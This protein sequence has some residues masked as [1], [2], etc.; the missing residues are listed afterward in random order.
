MKKAA[1]FI[2][3]LAVLLCGCKEQEFNLE[4]TMW[5]YGNDVTI[6]FY[7]DGNGKLDVDGIKLDFTYEVRG[8]SLTVTCLNEDIAQS[9]GLNTL[10]FFGTNTLSLEDGCL[11]AGGWALTEIST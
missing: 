6:C 2:L 4:N 9:Y 5:K 3:L 7:A 1:I 10:P 8:E 11:Y